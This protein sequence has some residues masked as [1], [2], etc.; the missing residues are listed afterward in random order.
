MNVYNM[1]SNLGGSIH[2]DNMMPG[3]NTFKVDTHGVKILCLLKAAGSIFGLL[4]AHELLNVF[5]PILQEFT[6]AEHGR[7]KGIQYLSERTNKMTELK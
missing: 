5:K 3:N 2:A 1:I 6:D 4:V 7:T